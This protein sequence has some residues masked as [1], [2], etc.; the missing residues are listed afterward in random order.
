MGLP[1]PAKLVLLRLSGLPLLRRVVFEFESAGMIYYARAQDWWR[2]A[3]P[4]E[5]K[6]MRFLLRSA[7]PSDTFLD[8]GAH[9]G[10]YAVGLARRVARVYALEPEPSNF[11]LLM[12]NV[13]INGLQSKVVALPVALS[14][15]DGWAELCVQKSSGAHTL[16]KSEGCEKTVKVLTLRM[17]T[18]VRL[19]NLKTI[20]IVKI[21]V[22]GHEMKVIN[23]MENILQKNP[24]RV[25]VIEILR[26]NVHL[27]G[28]LKAIGYEIF[29]LDR[30]EG[31]SCNYGLLLHR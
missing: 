9:I 23:G 13:V 6:T 8:V 10:L 30:W 18:L 19:L 16:E 25:L 21:D 5:P 27:L 17:D 29:E 22:E 28:R 12:R 26:S 1:E 20:E 14:D 31:V 2:F 4:F 7:E 11:T 3:W 15:R 24:P